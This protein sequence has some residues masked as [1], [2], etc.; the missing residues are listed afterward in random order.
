MGMT[1]FEPNELF[2]MLGLL[3]SVAPLDGEKLEVLGKATSEEDVD[4]AVED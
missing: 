2:V 1:E 4:S 3:V